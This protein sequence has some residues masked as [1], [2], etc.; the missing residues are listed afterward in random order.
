MATEKKDLKKALQAYR[1]EFD[2]MQKIPCT[3]EENK[4]CQEILKERG[5][6]PE[7]FYAYVYETGEISETEFYTIYQPEL[8]E[9]EKEE[10]LT[11]KQLEYLK[12][13]KNGVKFFVILTII[14]LI[15]SFFLMLIASN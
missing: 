5:E 11:Y 6:L 3:K 10:Y 14:G 12:S 13:I 15:C 2:L 7:G 4:K 1:F 9:A 8:T